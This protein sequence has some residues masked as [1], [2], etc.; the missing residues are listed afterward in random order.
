MGNRDLVALTL[1]VCAVFFQKQGAAEAPPLL[2]GLAPAGIDEPALPAGLGG[3]TAHSPAHAGPADDAAGKPGL[4]RFWDTRVGARTQ[5]DD[6]VDDDFTLTDYQCHGG[7][8]AP[9]A[10]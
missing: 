1:F 10:V 6:L 7:I 8:K 2:A 3:D 9:I 5:D 4:V